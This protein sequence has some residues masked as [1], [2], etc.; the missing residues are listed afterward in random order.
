MKPITSL[1]EKSP[2]H[3]PKPNPVTHHVYTEQTKTNSSK[4]NTEVFIK[5]KKIPNTQTKT[6]PS[7]LRSHRRSSLI[8]VVVVACQLALHCRSQILDRRSLCLCSSAQCSV[9]P[10][11]LPQGI[12]LFS[13]SLYL[14]KMKK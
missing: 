5:K 8:V 6:K 1:A 12:S 10:P 9:L 13:L 4:P 7:N 2:I 14:T 11:A 3:K